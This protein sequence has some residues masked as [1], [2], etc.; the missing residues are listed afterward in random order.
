V[1]PERS[2]ATRQFYLPDTNVLI[3]RFF[4][5][6]GVGEIQ[7]F[8]PV[9]GAAET[10]RHRLIRWAV[11]VRGAMPFRAR[12][13]PRFGYGTYPHT[14]TEADTGVVF[15]LTVGLSATVPVDHDGRDVTAEFKLAEGES[16]VFALD[17]V[18]GGAVP[19]WP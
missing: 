1:V 16:V 9:S 4:T 3:T 5:E 13:A 14:L 7:D 18:S 8:M 19:R 2:P 6:N 11:C 15:S 10:R 17:E 12:I